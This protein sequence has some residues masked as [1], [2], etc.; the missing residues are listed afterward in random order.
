MQEAGAKRT[1]ITMSTA[2]IV[3]L[4]LVGA[5]LVSYSAYGYYTASRATPPLSV[6][7]GDSV[8]VNYTGQY[9]NNLIFDTSVLSIAQNNA[10]YPKAPGFTWRGAAGYKP[11]Q[12]SNVGSGQVVQG[13]DQGIIGMT[14]NQSKTVVIPPADGYGP[15]NTSLLSY[16]PLYQN[17]SML[18]T[19]LSATFQS[20]FGEAPQMGLVVKDPFW[21]WNVQVLNTGNGT[22]T[23]Q[24][25]PNAGMTLDPYTLNSTTVAGMTGFPVKVIAINSAADNGN[26]FI[27]LHNEIA[28]SMVKAVGG[29]APSGSHFVIW[30]LN[31]NGT[32]TLNFNQPVAGRTLIFTI[33]V[34]YISNPSTGTKTGI[35]GYSLY[36]S[37]SRTEL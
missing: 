10:S 19:V 29:R 31:S 27:E 2:V 23:Y 4:L 3:V 14:V 7:P 1:R 12:I 32:A 33:K 20:D 35:P 13:F 21:G 26:G 18:H 25:Q 9:T 28:A 16:I 17:V 6:Q 36:L 22:A 8:Y 11:L 5:G 15:L 34:T 24:Y 30:A 37:D